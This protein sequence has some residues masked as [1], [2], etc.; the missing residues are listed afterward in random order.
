MRR[1]YKVILGVSMAAAFLIWL[2][3][4]TSFIDGSPAFDFEYGACKAMFDEVEAARQR[5]LERP[6]AAAELDLAMAIMEYEY[7]CAWFEQ[8]RAARVGAVP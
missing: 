6:S 5:A 7:E 3:I 1:L 4:V 8:E 2:E